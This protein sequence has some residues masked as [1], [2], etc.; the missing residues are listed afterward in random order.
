M[1][2]VHACVYCTSMYTDVKIVYKYSTYDICTVLGTSD[3]AIF[4]D[5]SK[6]THFLQSGSYLGVK[7][8][9]SAISAEHARQRWHVQK[10]QGPWQLIFFVLNVEKPS[11]Y[12][13]EQWPKIKVE[14]KKNNNNY[15]P[16]ISKTVFDLY[17][18]KII[19]FVYL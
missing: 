19:T 6:P 12:I 7:F 4:C 11:L 16:K 15:F 5:F 3:L 10:S 13:R 1:W 17:K 14:K 8:Q 18:G 2:A 9:K